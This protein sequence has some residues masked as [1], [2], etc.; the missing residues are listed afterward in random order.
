MD[1]FDG[2]YYKFSQNLLRLMGLWPGQSK[3]I[4]WFIIIIFYGANLSLLVPQVMQVS[5]ILN[6]YH[7]IHIKRYNFF[8]KVIQ[9]AQKTVL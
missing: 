6:M 2:H 8:T 3:F 7:I 1:L 4:K 5:K 9:N